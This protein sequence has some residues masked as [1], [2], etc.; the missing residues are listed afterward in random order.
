MTKFCNA[1]SASNQLGGGREK[2]MS[3][4]LYTT[5]TLLLSQE[6]QKSNTSVYY[7]ASRSK[8]QFTGQV[9]KVM[10]GHLLIPCTVF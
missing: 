2:A 10:P 5:T 4:F 6:N 8:K 9:G 1:A 7:E 3:E